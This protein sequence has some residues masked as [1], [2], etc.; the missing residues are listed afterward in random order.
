MINY[1]VDD[2][3]KSYSLM[4]FFKRWYHLGHTARTICITFHNV[5]TIQCSKNCLKG[6]L[7][8]KTK[9]GFEINYRLLQVKSIAECS[10]RSIFQCFRPALGYPLPL[11]P[12]FC[13][14]FSG[15]FT[16]GLLYLC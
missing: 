13:L 9:I 6:T 12:L 4:D 15:L 10:K 8:K 7:K 2:I 5:Y 14:F 3:A 11:R 16:Q 1:V